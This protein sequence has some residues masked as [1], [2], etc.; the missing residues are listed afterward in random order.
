[1]RNAADLDARDARRDVRRLTREPA[2][3]KIDAKRNE[4]RGRNIRGRVDANDA[5]ATRRTE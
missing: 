1:V 2:P 4:R 3:F 5:G